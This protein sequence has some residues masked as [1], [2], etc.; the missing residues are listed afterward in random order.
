MSTR[1]QQVYRDCKNKIFELKNVRMNTMTK[2]FYEIAVMK[3]PGLKEGVKVTLT[4][5]KMNLL[6]FARVIEFGMN[7]GLKREEDM[8]ALL[9][10]ETKEELNKAKEE[11][12]KKGELEEFYGELNDIA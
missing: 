9:P 2:K 10:V 5:S 1:I 8:I 6:F 4:L 12:L 11:L 7:P 3:N